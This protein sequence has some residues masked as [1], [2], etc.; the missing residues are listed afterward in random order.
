MTCVEVSW[1]RSSLAISPGSG[2]TT[3]PKHSMRPSG[4]SRSAAVTARQSSSANRR[5]AVIGPP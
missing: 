4:T 1:Q 5:E 2:C 3:L